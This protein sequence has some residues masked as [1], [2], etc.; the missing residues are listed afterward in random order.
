MRI[1]FISK[2]IDRQTSRGQNIKLKIEQTLKELEGELIDLA[3]KE[4]QSIALTRKEKEDLDSIMENMNNSLKKLNRLAIKNYKGEVP[5]QPLKYYIKYM[6][7]IPKMHNAWNK[8]A[9]TQNDKIDTVLRREEKIKIELKYSI[10][11][12]ERNFERLDKNI[13]ENNRYEIMRTLSKIINEWNYM[14]RQ[15]AEIMQ[16]NITRKDLEE[17]KSAIDDIIE[18]FEKLPPGD[19]GYL[20]LTKETFA[21]MGKVFEKVKEDVETLRSHR[22]MEK[23]DKK[24]IAKKT[25]RS[26]N[27]LGRLITMMCRLYNLKRGKWSEY[28]LVPDLAPFGF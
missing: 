24:N 28:N 9:S 1:P 26:Y 3:K 23:I 11:D 8:L 21:Q 19:L 18:G 14:G 13:Q 15:L 10:E 20:N 27:R 4:R 25:I 6:E 7:K 22:V 16:A 2:M 12:N 5:F 17:L